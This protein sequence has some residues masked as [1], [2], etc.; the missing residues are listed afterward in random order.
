V[1]IAPRRRRPALVAL[2]VLVVLGCAGISGALVLGS[3]DT[4]PVLTVTRAVPA[5]HVMVGGDLAP[6]EISGTGLTAIAAASTADVLGMTAAVGMVPGTLL[7]PGM[8]TDRPVPGPG[9]AVVGLALTAGLL[10]VP[11]LVPG[12]RVMVVRVPA[13]GSSAPAAESGT[14]PSGGVLVPEAGVLSV[15]ADQ[16]GGGWLVSLV[17]DADAATDVARAGATGTASLVVIA[18]GP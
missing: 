7:S 2:G 14:E 5:G 12:A 9:Q 6:A 1:P 3:S 17:V 18:A 4:T 16:T 13:A 10:P 11:E 15:A 8:L